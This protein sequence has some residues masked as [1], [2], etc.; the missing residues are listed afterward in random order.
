MDAGPVYGDA[1]CV[2]ATVVGGIGRDIGER[3]IAGAGADRLGDGVSNVIGLVVGN[4]AGGFGD[5]LHGKLSGAEVAYAGR[6]HRIEGDLG[7]GKPCVGS[8]EGLLELVRCG[9]RDNRDDHGWNAGADPEEVLAPCDAR[10]VGGDLV[11]L[12][13]GRPVFEVLLVACDCH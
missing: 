10:E 12:I 3:V 4:A 5:G 6:I 9:T 11:H 8:A 7:V 1:N 13:D 2:V